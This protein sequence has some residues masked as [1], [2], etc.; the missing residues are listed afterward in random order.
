MA[1]PYPCV[2]SKI[3]RAEVA[4]TS[5]EVPGSALLLTTTMSSTM[6]SASKPLTTAAILL[7]SLNVGNTT[8]T[9]RPFHIAGIVLADQQRAARA[10]AITGTGTACGVRTKT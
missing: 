5:A 2:D 8:A 1:E 3:S 4:A 7:R 10:P 6:P 9:V